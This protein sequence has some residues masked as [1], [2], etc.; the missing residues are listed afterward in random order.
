MK[1]FVS[2]TFLTL[3]LG[4][5]TSFPQ[6]FSRTGDYTAVD[7][8][9][10]EP[11]DTHLTQVKGLP[12]TPYGSICRQKVTRKNGWG[13][14]AK[15][16][17]SS[18]AYLDGGILLTAAHNFGDSILSFSSATD[19]HLEC[20]TGYATPGNEVLVYDSYQSS[21][22]DL[23]F[24]HPDYSFTF[25]FLNK[26]FGSDAALI[27]LCPLKS[28]HTSAFR[29]A[30]VDEIHK[31]VQSA[32]SKLKPK[33]LVAGYP[34]GTP[35]SAEPE[36]IDGKFDGSRLIH[37]ETFAKQ[38]TRKG[39]I[40]YGFTNTVSGMSGGPVWIEKDTAVGKEYII[41]G[42]H[43]TNGG[44]FLLDKTII[45]EYDEMRSMPCE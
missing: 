38:V 22:D 9:F 12:K 25:A 37:V 10:A 13:I 44:A 7:G 34:H 26:R 21:T 30:T 20:Q 33:I 1:H 19:F 45:S 35:F 36:A 11:V 24:V 3:L 8:A 23:E 18:S 32:N 39:V 15:N 5:C 28:E 16:L 4:G 17:T 6:K 27:K 14:H 31:F 29:L 40:S 43:V 41:V 2:F 42:V